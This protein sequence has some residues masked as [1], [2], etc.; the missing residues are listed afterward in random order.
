MYKGDLRLQ[1]PFFHLNMSVLLYMKHFK[2]RK[3][4]ILTA[5]YEKGHI[6]AAVNI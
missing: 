4:Q 3:I 2:I 1:I 6:F 5:L